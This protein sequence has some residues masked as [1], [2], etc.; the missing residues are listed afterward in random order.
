MNKKILRNVI[1]LVFTLVLFI[2]SSV[3]AASM[4]GNSNVYVGDTVTVTFN[5]DTYVGAYD[6]LNVTYD[7]N[8]FEYVSGD[9]LSESVWWDQ[10]EESKGI[11]TKTYTFKAKKSGTSRIT[12]VAN[13]VTSA[14]ESMDS[15]GTLTAE[16]MINVSQRAEEKPAEKPDNTPTTPG[17]IN[18][19]S[20][21]A[22]GNNYLKY[23]Q[24]SEEGLTPNFTR[25]VTDYAISVGEN[26]NSIEVLAKAEDPNARVEVTGNTNIKDGDNTINIKVT[27]ENGYYRVYSIV[28]TKSANKEKSNAYL[29]ELIIEG[30]SLGK[31]FQ[32]E[33]LEYNIGEILSTI[34]SL[35]VVAT[36]KDKDAKI[37]IIG[38]NSLVKE[39]EGEIVI[40]VTAPD[41]TSTKEYKIKYNVKQA[42][43]E[44]I[45]EKEMKDYLKDIQNGKSKKEV[46]IAY[47]KYIWIA[48]K[49]NY[50]LVIMYLLVLF[51]FINILVL[52]RKIKKINNNADDNGNNDNNGDD[53][54]D[55]T[56]LKVEQEESKIPESNIQESVKIEPP[57]VE[58]LE[59]IIPEETEMPK[60]GRR[61]SLE[62][63]SYKAEEVQ[64]GGIKLVD[65]DKNEGPKD[66]LTFNIFDNLNDEDIK[67]M[68]EE[69][70]DKGDK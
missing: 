59:E 41:G 14:N 13:G 51:E 44:E 17:N 20:D 7:A 64:T 69:E 60:L 43:D 38:A 52:R 4:T 57:K 65:L 19:G 24:I 66:E 50:L 26:V 22:S 55:K 33:T 9:S 36:T 37:E 32:S 11:A 46:A 12:V 6:S 61:G 63:P 54:E 31:D 48:I 34:E 25:N 27:A 58:L 15:L 16:K 35:N 10:S 18:S 30:Y 39:G 62:K 29:E 1:A 28:V 67:R 42:T 3:N 49:K 8:I 53:S 23:L 2:G 40:K 70:I 68:L 45:A 5:F 56:I 47:L 21:T